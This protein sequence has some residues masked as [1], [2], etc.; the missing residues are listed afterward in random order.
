MFS[1]G[2]ILVHNNKYNMIRGKNV[3]MILIERRLYKAGCTLGGSRNMYRY[4][5][6]LDFLN[7]KSNMDNK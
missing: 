5:Y 4:R 3:G 7:M 6:E 1:K 2:L